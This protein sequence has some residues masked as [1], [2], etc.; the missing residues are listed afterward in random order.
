M[1]S[2]GSTSISHKGNGWC[3]LLEAWEAGD[4][5]PPFWIQL[6]AGKINLQYLDEENPMKVFPG[7]DVFLANGSR[8]IAWEP[9]L[10]CTFDVEA[11][12]DQ[13]IE[14]MVRSILEKHYGLEPN[15]ET[16]VT[17]QKLA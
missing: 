1:E 9:K 8:L 6:H 10:Y 5:L 16:K 2:V 17:I 14:E 13:D 4:T 12:E 7:E 15:C 11:V 3:T